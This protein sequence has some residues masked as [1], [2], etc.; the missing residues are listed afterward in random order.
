MNA[1]EN[2]YDAIAIATLMG[3]G[4]FLS[5][6][7][8]ENMLNGSLLLISSGR[9]RRCINFNLYF[10]EFHT[11]YLINKHTRFAYNI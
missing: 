10:S 1:N 5:I 3:R 2:Q 11:N 8:L 7:R 9:R 4:L 6:I